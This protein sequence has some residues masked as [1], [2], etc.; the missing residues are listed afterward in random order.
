MHNVYGNSSCNISAIAAL[1]NRQGF[2][3]GRDHNADAPL[4]AKRRRG[5]MLMKSVSARVT[6]FD[7][8]ATY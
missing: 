8:Y 3:T 7:S 4:K 1:H 6:W 2:F 5:W